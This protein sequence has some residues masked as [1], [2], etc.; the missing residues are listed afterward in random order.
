MPTPAVTTG[1]SASTAIASGAAGA[2][3]AALHTGR[4]HGPVVHGVSLLRMANAHMLSEERRTWKS[5]GI[6]SVSSDMSHQ[7]RV[8]LRGAEQGDAERAVATS[9]P[10]PTG[11]G[12]AR[13]LL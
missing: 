6:R 7:R 9:E 2:A 3:A 5:V 8:G 4:T 11:S 1:S 12:P 13:A 10:H